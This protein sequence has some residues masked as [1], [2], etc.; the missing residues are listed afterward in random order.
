MLTAALARTIQSSLLL[1]M[2]AQWLKALM[3]LSAMFD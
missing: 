1:P 3:A 2:K